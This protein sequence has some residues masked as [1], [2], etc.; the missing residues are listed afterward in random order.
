MRERQVLKQKN[1]ILCLKEMA[2]SIIHIKSMIP[3]KIT[4]IIFPI[5][6]ML[7]HKQ[8]KEMAIK[9]VNLWQKVI[10][11]HVQYSFVQVVFLL[12]IM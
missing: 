4:Y 5:V 9:N 7:S 6:K 2:S 3:T 11:A 10:L 12:N 8:N 1:P